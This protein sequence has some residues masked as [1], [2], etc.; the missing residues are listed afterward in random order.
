MLVHLA[1]VQV[2]HLYC[3]RYFRTLA[4]GI[5]DYQFERKLLTRLQLPRQVKQHDM[6]AARLEV[7]RFARRKVCCRHCTHAHYAILHAHEM[8]LGG[9]GQIGL[10][11]DQ[12]RLSARLNIKINTR[13]RLTRHGGTCP[14]VANGHVTRKREPNKRTQAPLAAVLRRSNDTLPSAS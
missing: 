2:A 6:V 14:R 12:L 9:I 1:A 7:H 11:T 5:F 10:N 8:D 3:H 13:D 4:V